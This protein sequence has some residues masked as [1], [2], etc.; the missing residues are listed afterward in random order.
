MNY[1]EAFLPM[2]Y[3]CTYQI[4]TQEKNTKIHLSSGAADVYN[5]LSFDDCVHII[6][7]ALCSSQIQR[8][9]QSS[10]HGDPTIPIIVMD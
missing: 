4:Q 5:P 2:H 10:N 3:Y 8:Q 7:M 1:S 9:E 6:V